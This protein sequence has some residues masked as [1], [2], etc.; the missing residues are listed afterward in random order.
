MTDCSTVNCHEQATRTLEITKEYES[1]TG[2]T[3]ENIFKMAYCDE[4][5]DM[6]LSLDG[7]ANTTYEEIHD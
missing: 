6:W 4:H 5:A 2:E 7:T 3:K 1:V